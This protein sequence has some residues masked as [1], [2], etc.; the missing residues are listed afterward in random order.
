MLQEQNIVRISELIT[1][2]AEFIA[3][4]AEDILIKVINY[5]ISLFKISKSKFINFYV[6][7]ELI[8]VRFKSQIQRTNS[9]AIY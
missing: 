4:T 7:K 6:R 9:R 3:K 2:G 1:E 5:N 8:Y